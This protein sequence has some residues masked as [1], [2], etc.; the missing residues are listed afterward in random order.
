[1]SDEHP[2]DPERREEN[3][4]VI[5]SED[6]LEEPPD[7]SP[8]SENHLVISS[9]D[10]AAEPESGPKAPVPGFAPAISRIPVPKSQGSWW[11]H[12]SRDFWLHPICGAAGGALAWMIVEPVFDESFLMTAEG[13]WVTVFLAAFLGGLIGAGLGAVE[14]ISARLLE[15]ALKSAAIG[16]VIGI[17]GGVVGL[18]AGSLLYLALHGGQPGAG[19]LQIFARSLGWAGMGTLIG[20]ARG[21]YPLSRRRVV[22]GLIGG[23][24]GGFIGGF[25]FDLVAVTTRAPELSRFIGMVMTGAGIGVGIGLVEE[26]FKEAWLHVLHGALLGKQFILDQQ[27]TVGSDP[28]CDI[29][30]VKDVLV[31]PWHCVIRAEGER[32]VLR[33]S[34]SGSGTYVN[35]EGI[36]SKRLRD[37][38]VIRVGQTA[39]VY[40]EMAAKKASAPAVGLGPSAGRPGR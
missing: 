13:R 3:P 8:P 35:G 27:T 22:N 2:A 20:L 16:F 34:G 37:R 28:K 12:I 18:F 29:V 21:L 39:F 1:M 7:G 26:I 4:L 11:S 23:A 40:N 15:R 32:F 38:D 31:S 17:V 10:L 14:G 25:L 19:F 5:R 6:L 9:E 33:D 36:T 30:L 24:C